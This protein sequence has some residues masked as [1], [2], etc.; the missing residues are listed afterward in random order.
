M[1]NEAAVVIIGG[2]IFGCS[3]AYHL[4]KKGA[5]PVV[6]LEKN[7]IASGTTPMAAG[8]VPQ[9]RATEWLTKAITYSVELYENFPVET[10]C[11]S[12]FQQVGSMKVALTNERVQELEAQVTLGKRLGIDIEFLSPHQAERLVPTLRTSAINA[13][14]FA[15]RDGFVN[16]HLA[17]VGFA[18]AAQR[19]G[20]TIYTHTPVQGVTLGAAGEHTIHTARG[21]FRSAAVVDAA[22]AWARWLGEDLGLHIPMMPVRHQYFIT[23][24]VPGVSST[25]PVV[26]FPDLNAYMRQENGGLLVGGFET[27]PLSVNLRALSPA[28]EIKDTPGDIAVLQHFRA[29]LQEYVPILGEAFWVAERRGLPTLT[30]DGDFLLGDVPGIPGFYLAT[31]CCVTGISAAPILGKLLAE[32]IVD[33]QSS[34]DLSPLHISRFGKAYED[35]AILRQACEA[36]YAHYYALGWGKI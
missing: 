30:P 16:P 36:A 1:S 24:P 32:L 34:L 2:G 17:A 26:R 20:V 22:G 5:R 25:Q 15:P 11:S 29:Q 21:A 7:T 3:I 28:F 4:A 33:G 31:G 23:A 10:G 14:T 35:P 9:L 27:N 18:T 19:L 12:V 8:L 13:I 6:L